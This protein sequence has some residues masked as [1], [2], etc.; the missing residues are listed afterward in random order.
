MEI[1]SQLSESTINCESY[2]GKTLQ[3]NMYKSNADSSSQGYWDLNISHFNGCEK[4]PTAYGD[5]EGRGLVATNLVIT[6]LRNPDVPE[7]HASNAFY[8]SQ[9]WNTY[10]LCKLCRLYVQM[11]LTLIGHTVKFRATH[12]KRIHLHRVPFLTTNLLEILIPQMSNL[13]VLGIY[14]CPLI[15]VGH[16]M[17]L[18]YIISLDRPKGREHQVYLDWFPNFH[19]GPDKNCPKSNYKGSYGVSTSLSQLLGG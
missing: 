9:L 18:L 1:C 17:D 15:H 16:G 19:V 13:E 4:P 14:K 11:L 6:P 10:M 3:L 2:L 12:F 5:V 8:E 7:L